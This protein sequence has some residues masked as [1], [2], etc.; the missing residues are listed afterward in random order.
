M[1]ERYRHTTAVLDLTVKW[2]IWSYTAKPRQQAW[3][4]TEK[5]EAVRRAWVLCV[6]QNYTMAITLYNYFR[7]FILVSSTKKCGC[8]LNSFAYQMRKKKKNKP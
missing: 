3:H 8:G 5:Q 2:H 4:M 1:H 7:L 6:S